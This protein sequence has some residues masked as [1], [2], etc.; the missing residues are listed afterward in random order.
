MKEEI[1]MIELTLNNQQHTTFKTLAEFNTWA[2]RTIDMNFK[3][4]I[5]QSASDGYKMILI[6]ARLRWS[7]QFKI[8]NKEGGNDNE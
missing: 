8:S 1:T 6:N 7:T 2:K 5:S 3:N 4:V